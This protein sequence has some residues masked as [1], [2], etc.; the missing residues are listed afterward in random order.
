MNLLSAALAL[1]CACIAGPAGQVSQTGLPSL[2]PGLGKEPITVVCLG[3]SVTGVYYH[4]GGLRAYP[5]MLQ[6]A[7]GRLYPQ[8]PPTVVNAGISG[9]TTQNGLDRLD[10]DVLGRKPQLVTISFG[11]ND[12]VRIAPEKFRANLVELVRRCRAGGSEVLLCTP[13]AVVDTAGRPT[14]RLIEYCELIRRAAREEKVAI[15]DQYAA[16]EAFRRRDAGAWRLSMSDEIHPNMAGHKRMAEELCR[17]I[18]GRDVSLDEVG[19]PSPAL[20]RTWGLLKAKKPVRVLAMPPYD[21]LIAGALRSFVTDA[22]VEVTPWP[23]SGKTLPE[24][25]QAANVLV[26]KL[27]PDLVLL[28]VPREAEASDEE[29]F[30]RSYSWIM[31]WSLSFG[32]QEWDCLV[33]HPAVAAPTVA[34]PRDELV[35]QLVR[36]QHLHLL[37]RADA[38]R[39]SMPQLLERRLADDANQA[40]TSRQPEPKN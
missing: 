27:K 20:A 18:T 15:C 1:A 33:A 29:R 16:G 3:D 37:D 8:S 26:R 11:L 39:S 40:A 36:A 28:A 23:T 17:S 22:Q 32:R 4:T 34:H 9:N 10:R 5:E 30:V 12:M 6:I 38:D 31:N 14:S 2:L 24:I 25:E 35:R 19:P 21:K 7:L 13:N